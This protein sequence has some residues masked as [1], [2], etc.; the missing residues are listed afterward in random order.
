MFPEPAGRRPLQVTHSLLVG[1]ILRSFGRRDFTAVKAS[2]I[3]CLAEDMKSV[4]GSKYGHSI[5]DIARSKGAVTG[6][7]RR[8]PRV[9]LGGVELAHLCFI[10]HRRRLR[11]GQPH[12]QSTKGN[13]ARFALSASASSAR[14][15]DPGD[16]R[17]DIRC[18]GRYSARF[19]DFRPACGS[20]FE[21]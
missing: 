20:G 9:L 7:D 21:C 17:S 4:S 19:P 13:I 2:I 12:P 10:R 3:G 1:V 8:Q 11:A 16:A 18:R 5:D 15:A 6:P 14:Q